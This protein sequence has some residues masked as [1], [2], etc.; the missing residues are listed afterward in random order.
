MV[1]VPLCCRSTGSPKCRYMTFNVS[2]KG[3]YCRLVRDFIKQK[4]N[5]NWVNTEARA[6]RISAK[7]T[8]C[9]M[10]S[11][12][13]ESSRR[14]FQRDTNA[15]QLQLYCTISENSLFSL[16]ELFKLRFTTEWYTKCTVNSATLN[17]TQIFL[18]ELREK[19]VRVTSLS[20]P[21]CFIHCWHCSYI[22]F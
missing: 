14:Y 18:E 15:M 1:Y 21:N 7:E 11:N 8:E 19:F 20:V 5:R 2:I 9:N 6:I 10:E 22:F 13:V 16:Y 4:L 12:L 17:N 3:R